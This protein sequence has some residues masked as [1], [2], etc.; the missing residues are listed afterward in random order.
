MWG[1]HPQPLRS[2]ILDINS[3][4][5][6]SLPHVTPSFYCENFSVIKKIIFV[7]MLLKLTNSIW[8]ERGHL[9]DSLWHFISLDLLLNYFA[10]YKEPNPREFAAEEYLTS[11]N[12][13]SYIHTWLLCL[14]HLN[15]PVLLPW[16]RYY[17]T[18]HKGNLFFKSTMLQEM[19]IYCSHKHVF[20]F[21]FPII[22]NNIYDV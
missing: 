13:K 14:C 19:F 20:C 18:V 1:W 8:K 7:R 10:L 21:A 2:Y 5:H 6:F 12:C 4:S 3:K 17:W 9:L 15:S 22:F 16:I 11:R